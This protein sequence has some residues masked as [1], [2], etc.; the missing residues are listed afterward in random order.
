MQ[1]SAW[2]GVRAA[3]FSPSGM[4]AGRW[5]TQMWSCE[6]IAIPPTIPDTHLFGSV[7]KNSGSDS[8]SGTWGR[9]ICAAVGFP[10]TA[11]TPIATTT[12]EVSPIA[13]IV[14]L[15]WPSFGFNAPG[16]LQE[17]GMQSY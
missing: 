2:G 11:A 4:V 5:K 6:S 16:A 8:N 13:H 17:N 14:R 9:L 12:T 10:S 7:L 1:H 3:A 15:M